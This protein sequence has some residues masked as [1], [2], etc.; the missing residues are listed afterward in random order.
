MRLRQGQVWK[1]GEEYFRIVHLE[2][3]EVQYK[4]L[5]N[6]AEREGSHHHVTKKEFCRLIKGAHLLSEEEIKAEKFN[7]GIDSKL[8]AVPAATS[9]GT[10]PSPGQDQ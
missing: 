10:A 1:K 5:K 9:L 8:D 3:L 4:A 2:R 7:S 6:L